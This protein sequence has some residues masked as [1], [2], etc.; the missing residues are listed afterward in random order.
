MIRLEVITPLPPALRLC[1]QCERLMEAQ[2]GAQVRL[3][4]ARETP[5][6]LQEEVER[7]QSWL[8]DLLRRYSDN[9]QVR[10]VD[11][12][13]PEGFWKCLR[14][15]IRRYPTFLVPGYGRV[16]GWDRPALE[17]LLEEARE[18]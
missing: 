2:L 12:Y 14:H 9:L 17:R 15:G 13:S 1:M 16:V 8:G 3:E 6:E 11:P 7:L 18:T 4:M 5:R 10:L